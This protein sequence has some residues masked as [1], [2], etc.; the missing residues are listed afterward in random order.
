MVESMWVIYASKKGQI[1]QNYFEVIV[2]IDYSQWKG[3]RGH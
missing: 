2:S 3:L 1:T